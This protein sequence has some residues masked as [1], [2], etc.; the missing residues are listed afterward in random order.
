MKCHDCEKPATETL[1]VS[2]RRTPFCAQCRFDRVQKPRV[3]KVSESEMLSDLERIDI[4]VDAALIK[5]LR[6]ARVSALELQIV[7]S[8]LRA[9]WI[10]KGLGRAG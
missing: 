3:R 9:I 1:I 8:S 10:A 2:M 6:N 7:R 5:T 4:G